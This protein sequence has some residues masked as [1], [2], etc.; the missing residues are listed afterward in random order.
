MAGN[1]TAQ[2]PAPETAPVTD[3]DLPECMRPGW[4]PMRPAREAQ[5]RFLDACLAEGVDP[6]EADPD[7][8]YRGWF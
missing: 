2:A 8:H 6:Y 1:P 4:D 5:A 3:N 7:G